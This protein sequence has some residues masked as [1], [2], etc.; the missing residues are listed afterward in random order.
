MSNHSLCFPPS[1]YRNNV[2]S[3]LIGWK[4]LE[5]NP[6]SNTDTVS[7]QFLW[8]LFLPLKSMIISRRWRFEGEPLVAIHLNELGDIYE[9]NWMLKDYGDGKTLVRHEYAID[10]R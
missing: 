8:S 10:F 7:V 4:I 6:D 1:T 3:T 5:S 2:D 9:S